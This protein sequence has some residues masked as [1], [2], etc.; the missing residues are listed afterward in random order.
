MTQKLSATEVRRVFDPETLGIKSTEDLKPLEGIIGQERAV[1]ALQFG[2]GIQDSGF[3][4]YVAGPH[5]IGKMTAIRSFLEDLAR[6]KERPLDWCHVNNFD[7]PYQ[8]KVFKLPAGRGRRLLQD[9]KDT[10]SHVRAELPKAFESEEYSARHDEIITA[11]RKEHETTQGRM[12]KR[13]SELGFA[14]Q[15]VPYGILMVPILGGHPL[16]DAEM[17]SLPVSAREEIQKSRET[18]QGELKTVLKQTREMERTAQERLRDLDRQVAHYIVDGLV[19]D[20]TEKYLDCPEVVEYL[21]AVQKD[22]LENIETLK[23]GSPPAPAA[24]KTEEETPG[25][26]PWA[27]ELSFRKYQVNVLVDNSQQEGAPVVVEM[28]PSYNNLFGRIEKEA[29]FGALYTDFTMIKAGSLHR[30]NGGYL[31]VRVEDLLRNPFS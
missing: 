22:I 27:R 3:N 7:D 29:Q 13:A 16:S 9:M 21:G 8:P 11:L 26:T 23:T 14:L 25:P 24:P 6:R 15:T 20:L 12:S 19:E 5:G 1:S 28:N 10:I 2:L 17:A 4:I 30:A 31:I 18:L